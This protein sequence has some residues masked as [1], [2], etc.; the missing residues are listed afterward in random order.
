MEVVKK[1]DRV[2]LHCDLN[3]FYASV[4]SLSLDEE[5]R[6]SRWWWAEMPKAATVLCWQKRSSKKYG[7]VTAETLYQA[8]K[9]CPDLLVLPPHHALYAHYSKVV[10][11]IYVRYSDYV[12]KFGIDE[13]WIDI[14][15]SMHLFGGPEATAHA[16]RETVKKK[17][18]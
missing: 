5:T 17:R 12:E 15:H 2:I 16:I 14:T 3:G 6:K 18:D 7:I 11:A 9:K 10:N 1:M 13:S 8:R 4:E